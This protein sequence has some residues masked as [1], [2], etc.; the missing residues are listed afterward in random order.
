MKRAVQV[1]LIVVVAGV[2]GVVTARVLVPPHKTASTSAATARTSVNAPAGSTSSSPLLSPSSNAS[3]SSVC[4]TIKDSLNNN[5]LVQVSVKSGGT[6]CSEALQ[7][8]SNYYN[9][10]S[11]EPQGSAGVSTFDGWTCESTSGSDAAAS[12]HDGDCTSGA[13]YISLDRPKYA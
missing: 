1:V 5:T 2:L 4:G 8:A 9:N 10:P 7:V 12:G 11:D 6:A 13:A 3:P